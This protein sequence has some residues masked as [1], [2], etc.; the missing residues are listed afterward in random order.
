[1]L[2]KRALVK[3]KNPKE[4]AYKTFAHKVGSIDEMGEEDGG[5]EE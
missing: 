1:M 3:A 2:Q 4:A 5:S